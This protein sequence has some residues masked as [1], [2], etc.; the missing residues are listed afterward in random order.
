MFDREKKREKEKRYFR[1]RIRR[2][3]QNKIG[4]DDMEY[5]SNA[6]IYMQVMPELKKLMI[7]GELKPGQKMPSNRDLAVLFKVNQ[8]TAARVYREMENEGCCYTRRGIGTF[9]SEEEE[10]FE[11]L[12]RQMAEELLGNFMKEM[13]DLG[14]QKDDIISQVADYKEEQE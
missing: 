7:K 6:P 11:N 5:N 2:Q 12:K 4:R 13:K 9:V 1:I 8:N 10:M 14:F 3:P